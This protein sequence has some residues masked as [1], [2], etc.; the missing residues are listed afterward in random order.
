MYAL[1]LQRLAV[2]QTKHG[3]IKVNVLGQRPAKDMTNIVFAVLFDLLC[4][5][6]SVAVWISF[7]PEVNMGHVHTDG[8]AGA[9]IGGVAQVAHLLGK[10]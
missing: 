5:D 6:E 7:V 9:V 8:A 1:R 10:V 2:L 3:L 4:R